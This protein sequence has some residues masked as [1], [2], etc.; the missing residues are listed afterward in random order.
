MAVQPSLKKLYSEHKGKLTDKWSFYLEEWDRLLAPYRSEAIR[1]L[2]IGVQNGGSL[3]IWSKYFPKA[4][5]IIGCDINESC[6][7]LQ[8]DDTRIGVIVGDA[9][10]DTTEQNILLQSATFDLIIDDGSHNSD[11][12]IRSFARYFP[13]LNEGGIYLVEDL[14]CS[15]WKDY[16]GGLFNPLSAMTFFKRLADVLNF[17]HWRNN[18]SR[19]SFL[20]GFATNLNIQFSDLDLSRIH[21][22]EF[23]NSYCAIK[24]LSPDK[25]VLNKRIV[26]GTSEQVTTWEKKLNGTA[27]LDVSSVV[28]DDSDLDVFELIKSVQFFQEALL[29]QDQNSKALQE[30]LGEQETQLFQ[31]DHQK[32]AL[33]Q[34]LAEQETQFFQLDHHRVALQEQLAE[35]ETQLFQLEQLKVSL[36][37]QLAEHGKRAS[38]DSLQTTSLQQELTTL[39]QYINQR[40]QILQDLNLKLLEIYGSTAWKI[41]QLMWRIR[42]WLAPKGSWREKVGRSLVGVPLKLHRRATK[43]NQSKPTQNNL[44]N[45]ATERI[46]SKAQG[47][48]GSDSSLV[49]IDEL[50]AVYNEMVST[51]KGEKGPEFVDIS[52]IDLSKENLPVQLIAFYLPQFHPI[53]ENDK[54]WGRGFTEWI[55]VSK[56]VPQ[57]VG[58]YQPHLPGE[59]GFYDLR[60][61]ET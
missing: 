60:V 19:E 37:A 39:K 26:T 56:A 25:N 44:S 51:S 17:E 16:N 3:E 12:I 10:T 13:Y 15:Y 49:Y 55:N 45:H 8:Y 52:T 23:F 50:Q 40:E 57:F 28:V 30:Q 58:H 22:I 31:L 2:E 61:R 18:K 9:N 6:K 59:L 47:S 14:H 1:L 48:N 42:L 43:R 29:K 7:N 4:E 21:S 11:D 53:P 20:N 36:Q 54:W 33:Q 41:I 32:A 35:Q 46:A 38:T 24:K 34:Q 5:K 27:A